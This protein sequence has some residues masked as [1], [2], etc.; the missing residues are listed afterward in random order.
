MT[1]E[2]ALA[3][4]KKEPYAVEMQEDDKAY[5]IK[6]LGLTKKEFENIMGLPIKSYW[7]YPSYGKLYAG[8]AYKGMQKVYRYLRY[9]KAV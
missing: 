7:D 5:V 4:L 2:V 8:S 1:R 6:K 3:E 9:R